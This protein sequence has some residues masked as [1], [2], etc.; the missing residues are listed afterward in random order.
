M[1]YSAWRENVQL[2]SITDRQ[3]SCFHS[4]EEICGTLIMDWWTA[5]LSSLLLA[6][7]K[8]SQ[9]WLCRLNVN[10]WWLT[11]TV[12]ADNYDWNELDSFSLP[13]MFCTDR[14]QGR[15]RPLILS[16]GRPRCS[17]AGQCQVRF[18]CRGNAWP[19]HEQLIHQTKRNISGMLFFFFF[20]F[21]RLSNWGLCV[22]GKSW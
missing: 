5:A 18:I 2:R 9:I 7:R 17:S 12:S 15:T 19:L 1:G 3:P 13:C 10:R 11:N 8:P 4:G 22:E 21:A 20:F 14:V 6:S 16:L